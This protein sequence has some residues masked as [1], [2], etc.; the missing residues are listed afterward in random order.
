MWLLRLKQGKGCSH[1]A[2]VTPQ[3][4]VLQPSKGL[5]SM[6][7][8]FFFGLAFLVWPGK[9]IDEPSSRP[10]WIQTLSHSRVMETNK[11]EQW[12]STVEGS[13]PATHLISLQV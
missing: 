13:Q 9:T 4:H 1:K 7:A 2:P 12:C 10:M 11:V 8:C 6:R 5:C 3:L